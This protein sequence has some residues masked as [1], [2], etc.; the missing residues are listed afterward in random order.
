MGAVNFS[1]DPKLV[2]ALQDAL[3]LQLL[4]ETGTFQGDTLNSVSG[5]FGHS[6]SI[7]LSESLCT[8]AKERFASRGDIEI[9]Q[10][11]SAQQLINARARYTNTPTLFW[12]DAHWCVA[13]ETSGETIQCPLLAELAAIGALDPYSVVLIDD[14]RLFVA[15]PP[16]PHDAVAWPTFSEVLAALKHMS[17]SHE[18]SIINDVIAFYPSAART[19]VDEYARRYGI[20]WLHAV[21]ALGEAPHWRRNLEEK[22]KVIRDL[23]K[24]LPQ[25]IIERAVSQI[26]ASWT[27]ASSFRMFQTFFGA[28]RSKV[29]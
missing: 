23:R 18:L 6:I 2:A 13:G 24:R 17:P 8:Q 4:V 14:A 25:R 26:R 15:T 21:Q 20:D 3:P 22:E 9:L 7:E 12:L 5:S 16:A 28:A 1:I 19:S 11:D 10:G 29:R 27:S